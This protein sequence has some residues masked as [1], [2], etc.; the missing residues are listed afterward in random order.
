MTDRSMQWGGDLDDARLE[1]ALRD[2]A[3]AVDW[4]P[5]APLVGPDVAMRVRVRLV[6]HPSRAAGRFGW[7]AMP[8]RRALLLAL[9]ALLA[10]AAIA[11]A[12]GLGLPGL[13]LILGQPSASPPP[14]VEPSRTVPPGPPGSSLRLGDPV[15]LGEVVALTGTPPRLP[16]DA[17]I[18][19]P[20]AV[21]VDPS[22]G[23]QVAVVWSTSSTLPA[24]REPGIGLL[25]MQF[26]GAPGD[27]FYTKVIGEGVTA[28]PVSVDGHDG[29]WIS[30][31]AHFFYYVRDDG[32]VIDDD[33]RWVD[34]ALVW[35]DGETTF[36]LETSLGRDAAIALAE[37]LD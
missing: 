19:A 25:L 36:R 13:R 2:L 5:A 20:D 31:A 1:A 21:Y 10:L 32:T 26:D 22:R 37:S 9:T 24:T 28:E 33:R 29:F 17:A 34:D 11:G 7:P 6:E 30:G 16:T 12:V 3:G 23:N 27:R 8:W 15:E 18:G 4:P 14:S 35:S